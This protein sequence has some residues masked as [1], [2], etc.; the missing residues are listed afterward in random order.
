MAKAFVTEVRRMEKAKKLQKAWRKTCCLRRYSSLKFIALEFQRRY[1]GIRDREKFR[2][3]LQCHKAQKIQAFTR[4]S[5]L[6]ARHIYFRRAVVT[7]QCLVRCKKSRKV[8]SDLR[9]EAN[10]LKKVSDE[11]DNLRAEVERM[12]GDLAAAQ[13]APPREKLSASTMH[14]ELHFAQ[15]N[16]YE[17]NIQEEKGGTSGLK[18]VATNQTTAPSPGGCIEKF[19]LSASTVYR[20][21]PSNPTGLQMELTRVVEES[22]KKDQEII[23]L[24]R[25]VERLRRALDGDSQIYHAASQEADKRFGAAEH[26]QISGKTFTS[27]FQKLQTLSVMV[28]PRL[29][30]SQEAEET[31]QEKGRVGSA[32]TSPKAELS[33]GMHSA[34]KVLLSGSKFLHDHLVSPHPTWEDPDL[35]DSEWRD[36]QSLSHDGIAQSL[37]ASSTFIV[38]DKCSS[39]VHEAVCLGE[40][41][42]VALSLEHAVDVDVEINQG[43]GEGRA[44]IHIAVMKSH[45]EIVR[46]L[47]EH[48]AMCNAQDVMGNTPLHYA[49]DV[50]M[51]KILIEQGHSNPNIPNARGKCVLHQA[52]SKQ[53]FDAVRYLVD[54]GA[55]V[56]VADDVQWLTPLHL[57]MTAPRSKPELNANDQALVDIA[58]ILCKRASDVNAKDSEGNTPMHAAAKISHNVAFDLLDILISNHGDP[59][60]VN[61]NGQTPLLLLCHNVN[62]RKQEKF[63][64]MVENFS[65][66]SEPCTA[67]KS[68]CTPL[69][70]A[71]YHQDIECAEILVRYGADLNAS[72]HKPKKWE[73]FW[74]DSTPVVLP[75]DM[76][77][78]QY[79]LR[80]LISAVKKPQTWAMARPFCMECKTQFGTFVR[81]HHCRHCGRLVCGPCSSVYLDESFFPEL[82]VSMGEVK[83]KARVCCVC[84][85]VLLSRKKRNEVISPMNATTKRT[86]H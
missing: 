18:V 26:P 38:S 85:D 32:V 84:E 1:R 71:L 20:D 30:Q 83:G 23:N 48:S 43:D 16:A 74:D 65:S 63:Y 7:L 72:W 70:L 50:E 56:D 29:S 81:N 33:V 49:R 64:Q 9:E 5:L 36:D 11:R 67:S 24:R 8:I 6:R 51:M 22:L 21:F 37:A 41:S 47:I 54:K 80:R 40:T 66:R 15:E 10:D 59:N 45:A 53:D 19:V 14:K 28:L 52:V 12:K 77:R 39:A 25:E 78:D 42:K 34:A 31:Y 27:P 58:K 3:I 73:A 44:P 17:E 46:A 61:K 62:L 75:F 35:S 82:F 76:V 60:I 57:I 4:M 86:Q 79:S 13:K 55:D 68:G 69:H 2:K